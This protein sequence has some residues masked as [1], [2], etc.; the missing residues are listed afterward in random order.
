[1]PR[2]HVVGGSGSINGMVYFRGHPTDFDDWAAAGNPG[3]SYR[4]VLPYFLRSENND[5]YPDSAYH[6][7]G[8]PMNVTFIKRP[9]PMTPA[10][11]EAMRGL[12][13]RRTSDF[14]GAT[15]E[16]YGPRQGTILN[17][18]R[19]S[20][21]TA[22]LKPASGRGNLAILTNTRATEILIENRRAVGV[23]VTDSAGKRHLTAGREVI[24][25][26]GAIL[27]PQLL[28]LSGIGDQAELYA[29]GIRI[30]HHLPG[31]GANYHDHLAIGVLME[32]SNPQ[33][34]GISWRAAPRD[35][36]NI[37]EY[38]L[39]RTG[40]LASNVFEATGFIRTRPELSRP[41]IQIV[42]QAARRN[43]N[44]FPFPLG[45]GYA[46]SIVGLDPKSRGRVRLASADPLAA[47]L[48]DPQL[49][50]HP[51]DVETL[52]RG[53]RIGRQVAHSPAFARYRATEVAPGQKSQDDAAILD[54]IRKAASTVHHPC[55][56][57]RMGNDDGAVVDEKLCVRGVAGLRVADASVFPRV[58]SGNTNAAVVMIAEKAADLIRG[59]APPAPID[60]PRDTVGMTV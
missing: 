1:I 34:Y 51:D 10:F 47:P 58:V 36:L 55:G 6:G 37:L 48:V 31:V 18:R 13:Y 43:P 7:Q 27:S 9:N 12:G 52:L 49:F 57:C 15:T 38:A 25:A 44:P 41:D 56:S 20:T 2:G 17:G 23:A 60:L 19:V 5:A 46:I 16:G 3:W 21:A 26:A 8:G 45:H 11:L 39:F 29:A 50:S 33:S 28:M 40:P 24:V 53:F 30:K 4:E 35:L 42:F 32:M 59:I 22:Y 54:Y 14:N